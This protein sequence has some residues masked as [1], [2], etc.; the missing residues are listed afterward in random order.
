M[1]KIGLGTVQFGLNYGVSNTHGRVPISGVKD[2]L[3][4]AYKAGMDT[5]DTAIGYGYSEEVLGKTGV[6]S[7]RVISKLPSIPNGCNDISGWIDKQVQ[8]SLARLDL[9]CLDGILMHDPNDL[10]GSD[11]KLIIK[12]LLSLKEE[13]LVKKIG[14]SI[15]D[16]VELEPI[17]DIFPIDILQAPMNILDRRLLRSKSIANLKKNGCEIH[18]RSIFLQGLLLMSSQNRPAYFDKWKNLW[19]DWNNW[20]ESENLTGLEA[21][22]SYAL[23]CP[24]VDRVIIGVSSKEELDQILSISYKLKLNPPKALESNDTDLI[25]PSKWKIL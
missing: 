18:I 20:L 10:N 3:D 11:G 19:T 23:G 22:I 25:N 16:P 13:N 12:R 8:D 5:L 14:L 7:W 2:I 17:T 1:Q 4:I 6:K 15:Y 9:N 24:L 21:C